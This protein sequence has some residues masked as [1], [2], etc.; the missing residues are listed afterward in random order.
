M[1]GQPPRTLAD[2]V[3]QPLRDLLSQKGAWGFLLLVLL[4]KVGDAF[5]LSLYSAFMIKGWDSPSMN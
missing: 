4:Y 2:A 1:P 3:W 5:A